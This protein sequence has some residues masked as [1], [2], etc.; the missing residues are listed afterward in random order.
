MK[1]SCKWLC[2]R[3][4]LVD[5]FAQ[6]N[7]NSIRLKRLFACINQSHLGYCSIDKRWFS[8]SLHSTNSNGQMTSFP[9]EYNWN[10]HKIL[11]NLVAEERKKWMKSFEKMQLNRRHFRVSFRYSYEKYPQTDETK[12]I[13][14]NGITQGPYICFS[15]HFFIVWCSKLTERK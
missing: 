4:Y 5:R 11:S 1:I 3:E 7:C 2:K 10:I 12:W 8:S 14:Q 13:F 15:H 6:V 9:W